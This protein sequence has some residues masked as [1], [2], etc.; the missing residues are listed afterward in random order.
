[1]TSH[2][3]TLRLPRCALFAASLFSGSAIADEVFTV[4][5]VF[6]QIDQDTSDNLCRTA[7]GTCT[8]RAAVMQAGQMAADTT[9]ILPAGTYVLTLGPVLS[10]DGA[11]GDLNFAT[12]VSGGPVVTLSGAGAATTIIDASQMMARD[13]VLRVEPG[14]TAV[15]KGVTLRG[16]YAENGGAIYNEGALTLI[17][18]TLRE[19][20]ATTGGAIY[21][22][23]PSAL[24]LVRVHIG[25]GNHAGFGGGIFNEG[26]MVLDHSSVGP[27]NSST[28]GGGGIANYE[29]IVYGELELDSSSVVGNTAN[30]GGGIYSSGTVTLNN[31]S[32]VGNTAVQG[33]GGIYNNYGGVFLTASTLA[34]NSADTGGGL[35]NRGNAEVANSTIAQNAARTQGGGIFTYVESGNSLY[36]TSSTI[37]YNHAYD[38]QTSG[39]GGGIYMT[40]DGTGTG[41]RINNSL[42]VENYAGGFQDD[43]EDCYGD[44][45]VF[46]SGK[47]LTTTLGFCNMFAGATWAML[48]S[49]GDIDILR[50]NGG[51][52]QTIALVDNG[53]NNAIDGGDPVQGC[54]IDLFPSVIPPVLIETDQ[55][56]YPRAV[57]TH[58]DIG[59]YEF[60][61][62]LIF[63]D[64]FG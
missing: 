45:I 23:L 3:C 64:S 37:A 39:D 62:D 48:S 25:P 20:L 22:D 2:F 34:L 16:G 1:M 18:S 40:N 32:I 21:N 28:T 54:M 10:D 53:S 46:S 15:V 5:S 58:C 44:G 41:I 55:R 42:L 26:R 36:I 56:G 19:C 43:I 27:G 13:R 52:T 33:G 8:L 7:A 47:N 61:P 50:D 24:T 12:P 17:D 57:G 4:N 30:Q 63:K 11:S 29:D 38:G 14:R 6:D 49:P 60:N 35:T 51:Q 9:I 31:S 59:A